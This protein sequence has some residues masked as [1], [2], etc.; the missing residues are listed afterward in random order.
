MHGSVGDR[1]IVD[2]VH[3]D[4][5]PRQGVIEAVIGTGDAA[6]FR[7]RWDDGHETLFFPGA[8]TRI[9]SLED[10]ENTTT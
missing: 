4:D 7:V 9:V 3:V 8:T 10:A 1:I 2:G 6:H 5:R